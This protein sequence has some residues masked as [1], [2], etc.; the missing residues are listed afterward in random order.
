MAEYIERERALEW[1]RCYGHVG[2]KRIPYDTVMDDIRGMKAANVAP[3]VHG[4]WVKP[5]PSD[6]DHYCSVCKT[7]EPWFFGYGYCEY[8]Y[9]PYCGAKMDGGE[10]HD[11]R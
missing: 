6:G 4:K 1:F 9:C 11:K 10:A 7:P 3:V 8:D 5:V 2:E